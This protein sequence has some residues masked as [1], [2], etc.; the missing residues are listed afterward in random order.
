VNDAEMKIRNAVPED[1]PAAC[2]VMRRSI[3]ELCAA[4]HHDDPAILQRWLS[5]KTPE[6]FRS[7]IKPENALLVAVDDTDNDIL[8]VGCVTGEGR[9]TLNYVSPDARFRG[10][11]SALLTALEGRAIEA[12]NEL[13]MLDSTETAR[14]FYLARGY[15]ED[16]RA[17]SKFGTSGGHPMSKRLMVQDT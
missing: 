8:A 7:W 5:N 17:N 16:G 13:C 1:A 2:Q 11:S 14:H 12:G 4:D 3:A 15:S 6:V 9:I 10:V